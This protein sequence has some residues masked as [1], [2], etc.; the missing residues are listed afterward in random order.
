MSTKQ[1]TNQRGTATMDCFVTLFL[2]V[3][4]V[5]QL[6]REKGFSMAQYKHLPVY[7]ATYDLLLRIMQVV[8]KFQREYKYTLGEKL[9]HE[10]IELVICIYKANSA[11]DKAEYIKSILE[12]V[13]F[14]EL[15]LRISH[16]LKLLS[17]EHYSQIVEMTEGIAKQAQGWLNSLNGKEPESASTTVRQ[18]ALFH[19]VG[20][21]CHE[22]PT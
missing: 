15:F 11:R 5:H 7:K 6:I 19:L 17:T 18:R 10:T 12:H 4:A 13:Q 14:V 9:Q 16:D 3:T 1:S 8:N 21:G 2:A 20:D 22:Q